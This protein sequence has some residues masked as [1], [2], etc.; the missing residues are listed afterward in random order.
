MSCKFARF[1]VF[2]QPI[3]WVGFEILFISLRMYLYCFPYAFQHL[4][5]MLGLG[6]WFNWWSSCLAL[7]R[8]QVRIPSIHPKMCVGA[9]LYNLSVPK[10]KWEVEESRIMG[11]LWLAI[12]SYSVS[13]QQPPPPMGTLFQRT[14]Q[15]K[16][17]GN[18]WGCPPTST[19]APLHIHTHISESTCM[20]LHSTCIFTRRVFKK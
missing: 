6:R 5:S 19:R 10:A 9:H 20:H 18:T 3:S 14:R 17:R 16:A 15:R 12:L 1:L 13:K 8:T 2:S 7:M 4:N 11:S